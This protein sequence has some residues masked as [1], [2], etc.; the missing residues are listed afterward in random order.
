M[1]NVLQ[2]VFLIGGDCFPV[3]SC[4]KYHDQKQLRGR[5]AVFNQVTVLSGQELKQE[6]EAEALLGGSIAVLCLVSVL[7]PQPRLPSQ[8][9]LGCALLT[10]QLRTEVSIKIHD[11]VK[12]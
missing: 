2:T 6:L 12:D 10:V 8:V 4:N 11:E 7:I 1:K 9:T 3:S 5:K